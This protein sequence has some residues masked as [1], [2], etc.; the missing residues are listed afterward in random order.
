MIKRLF[1]KIV[2]LIFLAI[3]LYFVITSFL[4]V[5]EGKIAIV[6]TKLFGTLKKYYSNRVNFVWQK[7]IPFNAKVVI[8]PKGD[9]SSRIKLLKKMFFFNR[10]IE[11]I[12]FEVNL[13][14]KID[15]SQYVIMASKFGSKQDVEEYIKDIIQE[16]FDRKVDEII[17]ENRDI[18]VG[19][20]NIRDEFNKALAKSFKEDGLKLVSIDVVP[21]HIPYFLSIDAMKK[22][23]DTLLELQLIGKYIEAHPEVLKYLLIQKISS[24]TKLT[25]NSDLEKLY[26]RNDKEDNRKK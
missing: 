2:L 5:P 8:Y 18:R 4:I 24:N 7:G 13:E 11:Y 19:F 3:I 9:V 23:S 26:E 22:Y 14:W 12:E 6:K 20:N 10:E 1:K 16:V 21:V 15:K 17:N 25:I